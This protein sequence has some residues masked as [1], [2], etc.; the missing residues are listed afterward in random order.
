MFVTHTDLS[1][2]HASIHIA[3]DF[4]VRVTRNQTTRKGQ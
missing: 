2:A 3:S 1:F 4:H